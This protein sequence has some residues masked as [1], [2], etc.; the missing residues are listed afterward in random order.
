MLYLDDPDFPNLKANHRNYLADESRFNEVIPIPNIKI[1]QR[2]KQTFKLQFLKDVVLARLLDDP[3]FSLLTSMIYFNQIEIIG[4]LQEANDFSKSLF[5]LYTEQQDDGDS[6][7]KK[8]RDGVRFI[9]QLSLVA[10]GLGA[11]QR[12]NLYTNLIK[13]GLFLLIH[14]ALKDSSTNIRILGTEL[15]VTIIDYDSSLVRKHLENYNNK[16]EQ[17]NNKDN[18][19]NDGDGCSD[20]INSTDY[21]IIISRILIDLLLNDEDIGLR[22]QATEAFKI[23]ISPPVNYDGNQSL[24]SEMLEGNSFV[25]NLYDKFYSQPIKELMEPLI[26]MSK[27]GGEDKDYQ[28]PRTMNKLSGRAL[29]EQLCE[30]LSFCMRHHVTQCANFM[31]TNNLWIGIRRLIR[32]PYKQCRVA[33]IKCVKHAISLDDESITKDVKQHKLIGAIFDVLLEIGN[34]NNLIHSSCLELFYMIDSGFDRQSLKRNARVILNQIVDDYSDQL[35]QLDYT[36]VSQMLLSRYHDPIITFPGLPAPSVMSKN[37]KKKNEIDQDDDEDNVRLP[38]KVRLV[39]PGY[40]EDD[41]E[42]SGT[43]KK[44]QPS[45]EGTNELGRKRRASKGFTAED[46]NSNV[47]DINDEDKKSSNVKAKRMSFKKTLTAAGKKLSNL[48]KK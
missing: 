16:K 47:D 26:E 48:R 31:R 13:N 1:R 42:D 12:S 14:F 21:S 23:L 45:E 40:Y 22:A 44:R 4:Y 29:Y 28:Y 32:S 2:I 46:F 39:E 10:K 37:E 17:E 20:G 15:M 18:N 25:D 36:G 30:I 8:K 7:L 27:S 35:T 24:L 9:H 5:K 43:R 11:Q 38:K 41:D 19:D 34:Q 6:A 33:A 3:T